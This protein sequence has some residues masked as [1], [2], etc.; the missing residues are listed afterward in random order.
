VQRAVGVTASESSFAWRF[1]IEEEFFLVQADSGRLAPRVPGELL[2]QARAE[3]GDSVTSELLQ[4]QI[5]IASPILCDSAD[6]RARMNALRSGLAA[7]AARFEL[8]L[9]AAGTHPQGAWR[10]Q[11]TTPKR[12]YEKLVED[13]QIIARRSLV[14]GLHVHVELPPP[15]ERVQLMNRV[16]PW[17]PLFLALSTSSP[18]WGSQRTGLLSYRQSMYDEWPRTGIPDFLADE[19]EYDALVALLVRSGAIADAGSLWWGIRPARKY[20]TLEL[21]IADG[22]TRLRDSLAIAA[23]YRCLLRLLVRRPELNATHTALTRRVIDENRWRARRF[24]LAAEFIREDGDPIPALVLLDQLRRACSADAQ[25]LQCEDLLAGLDAIVS[26]GTSADGQL[27]LYRTLRDAGLAR[28][29]A[30]QQVVQWL[31][32]TTQEPA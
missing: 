28:K 31:M 23:L 14:C 29:P 18:F 27:R 5:E 20:P 8:K 24:G 21:R 30:L 7:V 9:L 10:E 13:F 11:S 2:K 15:Q 19:A 32:N 3:L 22:C 6:A 4:S 17:L 26:E 16:L 12:R 25:A 1:G